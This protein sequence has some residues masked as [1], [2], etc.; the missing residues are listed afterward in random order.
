[1]Q[2]RE[3][4]VCPRTGATPVILTVRRGH[5]RFMCAALDQI[6]PPT[7]LSRA[8]MRCAGGMEAA[9][10][11]GARGTSPEDQKVV[12]IPRAQRIGCSAATWASVFPQKPYHESHGRP[13]AIFSQVPAKAL[14]GRGCM[15]LRPLPGP[16]FAGPN[17][18]VPP[19]NSSDFPVRVQPR[20]G[21]LAVVERFSPMPTF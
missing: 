11:G 7:L 2:Y 10:G 14:S 1:M 9:A 5:S 17:D 21:H 13:I 4:F 8:D 15:F 19:I 6:C 20:R 3:Y 16:Y 12:S 18:Q